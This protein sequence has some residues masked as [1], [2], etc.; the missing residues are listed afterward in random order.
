MKL[1]YAA[2]AVDKHTDCHY[3]SSGPPPGRQ[4][5]LTTPAISQ[6]RLGTA[7]FYGILILLAY[8]LYR[9]FEP[10][11]VPLAW[12]AVTVVVSYPAYEWASR[13]WGKTNSALASTV[14]ITIILI[15]PAVF[16]MIA[17][18]QQGV[19]AA[20]S[21]ELRVSSGHWIWLN[22]IWA[23]IQNRFPDL[24]VQDLTSSLRRY[25]EEAASFV[26]ARLGTILRSTATFLFD[27]AVTIFA[28]FY[29]FRDGHSMVQRLREV[30]PFEA[31]QRNRM[32]G[33]VRTMIFASVTS[34]LVAA[35]LDGLLGGFVFLATGI[36]APVFW[37]VMMAFFSFVPVLGS[38]LIWVPIG[39]GLMVG[40]HSGRGIIV[41][42]LCGVIVGIVD[43][44][45]RPFFISGE[46][47]M[48]GLVIFISVVGGI[49]VFGLLGIVLGPIVVATAASL[50]DA[51]SPPSAG[52][53]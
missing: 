41:I 16:V 20:Q 18:V 25:G 27:L 2:T 51:Y 14:G 32:I 52:N 29:L 45:V 34:S 6:Q 38:A 9:V 11:L 40:G 5:D 33:K 31:S 8:L 39:I 23:A 30:L 43:S 50:L 7:F 42:V 4:N 46:A 47:E 48:S 36:K 35:G 13:R 19:S 28:M 49:S 22:R 26:A 37:G 53:T 15:V 21:I 1:T 17:F 44:L 10:F 24:S 3:V 12:A